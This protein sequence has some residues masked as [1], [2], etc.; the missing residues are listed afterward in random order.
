MRSMTEEDDDYKEIV[1]RDKLIYDSIN[2]RYNLEWERSKSLEGKANGIIT[3][4]GI[5][6]ALQGGIGA[7]LINDAPNTGTLALTI[8][9]IFI[10]SV[11]SLTFSMINGLRAFNV[12]TWIYF[13]NASCL[14]KQYGAENRSRSQILCDM[15]TT[16]A[17]S[18]KTN[19]SNND[20]KKNFIVLGFIFL[21]AGVTLNLVF[22]IGLIILMNYWS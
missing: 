13:P 6:L 9:W 20:E 1:E 16:L 5:I 2:N 21:F 18:I 8:N 4:V 22:I 14:V 17:E 10:L 15:S 19:K 11:I 12:K 7:I 3:F